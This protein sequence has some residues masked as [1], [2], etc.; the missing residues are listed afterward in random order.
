MK[1]IFSSK[2]PKIDSHIFVGRILDD[3]KADYI[4]YENEMTKL[5][6]DYCR[7]PVTPLVSFPYYAK[8]HSLY[9]V[10]PGILQN[11]WFVNKTTSYFISPIDLK[12]IS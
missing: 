8:G 1:Q 7:V 12:C 10:G 4:V 11:P 3:R 2:T 6:I 9:D 5:K